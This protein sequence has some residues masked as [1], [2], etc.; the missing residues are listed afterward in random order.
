[1]MKNVTITTQLRIEAG[2][3]VVK[4]YI[5]W[6]LFMGFSNEIKKLQNYHLFNIEISIYL[7]KSHSLSLIIL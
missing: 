3:N 7:M 2:V 6:H 4:S 5:C 1:M